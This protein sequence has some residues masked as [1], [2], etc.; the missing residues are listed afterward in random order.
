M[1]II[2]IRVLA[3]NDAALR[4]ALD[5]RDATYSRHKYPKDDTDGARGV[6]CSIG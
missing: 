5:G 1:I 4:S 3:G 2:I 6:D